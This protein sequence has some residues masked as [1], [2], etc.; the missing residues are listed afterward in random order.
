M[1]EF[2]VSELAITIWSN[3]LLKLFY[4]ALK[5]LSIALVPTLKNTLQPIR[6]ANGQSLQSDPIIA[7]GILWQWQ[8]LSAQDLLHPRQRCPP[9]GRNTAI[10][11]PH[12]RDQPNR[13]S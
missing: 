3:P 1:Q 11:L 8:L 5:A 12:L 10:A 7:T 6:E 9:A 2:S 13:I 4:L